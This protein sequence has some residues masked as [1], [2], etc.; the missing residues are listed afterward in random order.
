VTKRTDPH[1]EKALRP[2][3]YEVVEYIY[4]KLPEFVGSIGAYKAAVEDFRADMDRVNEMLREHG[5][6]IHGGW[7][8]CDHCGAHYHHGVL[9]RHIPTGELITIGWQC[10]DQRFSLGNIAYQRKRMDKVMKAIRARRG[11]FSKLRQF[12]EAHPEVRLLGKYRDIGFFQSLRTQLMSRLTLSE[13]QLDAIAPAII[14]QERWKTERAERDARMPEAA[15]VVEGRITSE[16]EV[17]STKLQDGYYGSEY[18]WL[19][20]DDRGFKVWGTIPAPILDATPDMSLNAMRG[21]RVTFTATVTKSDRDENFGF[22]K[23]PTKATLEV[24]A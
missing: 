3:D 23:R 6:M 17:L 22:Y 13:K 9:C 16:G 4:T 8:T 24:T 14:R 19:V 21:Q 15:P 10:A 12:V 18:K 11:R 7:S 20:I 1:A 2:E 5:A